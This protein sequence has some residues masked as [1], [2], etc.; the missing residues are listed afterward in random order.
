[1]K[2]K[3]VSAATA[4]PRPPAQQKRSQ[5]TFDKL[6]AATTR[7]LEREGFDGATVPRIAAEARLSPAS[8]YRRFADKDDLLRA[9]FLRLLEATH[10]NNAAHLHT[11]VVRGDLEQTVQ[12]LTTALLKQYRDHPHLLRALAR[13]LEAEPESPFATEAR[14]FIA[15][16]LGQAADVLLGHRDSIRHPDPDKAARFAVL[17]AT[18]AIELAAFDQPSL[19]H[20]VLPLNDKTLIA[21]LTRQT[22]AYLRRKP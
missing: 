12:A 1:M 10:A 19:W 20:V 4:P 16:N 17:S 14:K 9:S 11:L 21:E 5:K 18:S 8:I 7:V 13:M 22:V 2:K 6:L 15:A 3:S